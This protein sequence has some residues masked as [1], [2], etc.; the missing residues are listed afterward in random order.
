LKEGTEN[1]TFTLV[2]DLSKSVTININDGFV[3]NTP[4][5]GSIFI[6]GEPKIGNTLS[7]T[8]NNVQDVDGLGVFKFQWLANGNPIGGQTTQNYTLTQQDENKNISVELGFVDGAGNVEKISSSAMFV[9]AA[10]KPSYNFFADK[11]N[12]NE[13]ETTNLILQTQNVSAGKEIKLKFMGSATAADVQGN[14]IPSSFVVNADGKASIPLTFLNDK[15]KEGTENLTFTL[16]DDPSKTVTININDG[17]NDSNPQPQNNNPP[18]GQIFIEGEAKIGKTLRVKIDNVQ[19]ADG[20]GTFNF[21]WL[22]DGKPLAGKT[23]KEY[24]LE[25]DDAGKNI[26]VQLSYTDLLDNLEMLNSM[27]I[28]TS[29][30]STSPISPTGVTT[31]TAQNPNFKGTGTNA[32]HVEGSAIGDSIAGVLGNDTLRGNSGDDTIDGGNGNDQLFGDADS[33]L[34]LGGDGDDFLDGGADNDTLEGG[35]GNDT[36]DG[37][38]GADKMTGGNGDDEYFIDN[39]GDEVIEST[40]ATGGKDTV[41]S[42]ITWR[43][44]N[45]IEKINLLGENDIDAEGDNKANTITG[46]L[47]N[48]HLKGNGGNDSLFG[49][50]GND[51]LDGGA[52]ADYL[53]GGE[54]DDVYIIDNSAD[55]IEDS[56]GNDSVQSYITISLA[57]YPTIENLDLIG[58]NA[59]KGTGNDNNNIITGNSADNE[60]KGMAGDDI[61]FGNDGD[62]TLIG[63]EGNNVLD[64]GNDEDT[65][66]YHGLSS[67]YDLKIA[68]SVTVTNI[69]TGEIDELID[70]EFVQFNDTIL[71]IIEETQELVLSV[72]DVKIKEGNIKNGTV[73]ATIVLKLDKTPDEEVSIDVTTEDITAKSGEDYV[74]FTKTVTFKANQKTQKIRLDIKSDLLAEDD[75]T[76][77]LLLSNPSDNVTLENSEAIV[78]ILNDDKPTISIQNASVTEGAIGKMNAALQVNLSTTSN[79]PVTVSYKTVN[80]TAKSPSDYT[81]TSGKLTFAAGETSK[82]ILVPIVDDKIAEASEQFRVTLSSAKNAT[83]ATGKSTAKVTILD[84]DK[85]TSSKMAIVESSAKQEIIE[86]DLNAEIQITGVASVAEPHFVL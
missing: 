10:L 56:D 52:G 11:L 82:T 68:D 69:L 81:A 19:D 75:E 51:T 3:A 29:G 20:L 53:N 50:E 67:D 34:L 85:A 37:G 22:R 44:T 13:G 46:N 2:D 71:P 72:A 45:G 77:A 42:T 36:L 49:N 12:L 17:I 76:F 80:G 18:T 70:M 74:P 24:V 61:L 38:F 43:E 7:A 62:D 6:N 66:V 41:H 60:L 15:L 48:N 55:V 58:E 84:N 28:T 35:N 25:K 59:I 39:I 47:G 40:S 83:L 54:G 78:T 23:S 79:L 21:Q 27:P 64:G 16:I 57:A 63:G 8:P 32:D 5:T 86:Q 73:K 1:L 26:S 30:S 14:F 9:Q 33:D 31:L 65:A 4:A